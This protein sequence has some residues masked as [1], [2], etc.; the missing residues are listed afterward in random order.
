[1]PLLQSVGSDEGSQSPQLQRTKGC[2]AAGKML[3]SR[4]KRVPWEV[5]DTNAETQLWLD[6]IE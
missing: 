6:W 5:V 4:P 3:D 1:M 2:T